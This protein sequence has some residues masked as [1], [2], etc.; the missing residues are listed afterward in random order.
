MPVLKYNSVFD[1]IQAMV[2]LKAKIDAL[3]PAQDTCTV[4][5]DRTKKKVENVPF[6]YHCFCTEGELKQNGAIK[7]G[8]L[9]FNV[10]DAVLVQAKSPLFS[11]WDPISARYDDCKVVGRATG[12]IGCSYRFKVTRSYDNKVLTD[13]KEDH[14]SFSAHYKNKSG[15]IRDLYIS[16]VTYDKKTQFHTLIITASTGSSYGTFGEM[17]DLGG[18]WVRVNGADA[19]TTQYPDVYFQDAAWASQDKILP[20]AYEITL[21]YVRLTWTFTP[22]VAQTGLANDLWAKFHANVVSWNGRK[23]WPVWWP[24]INDWIDNFFVEDPWPAP[25]PIVDFFFRSEARARMDYTCICEV[26]HQI[27]E[28]FF[29]PGASGYMALARGNSAQTKCASFNGVETCWDFNWWEYSELWIPCGGTLISSGGMN[30]SWAPGSYQAE[31]S[32]LSGSDSGYI[33]L[34]ITPNQAG[35]VM[36]RGVASFRAE[37][38]APTGRLFL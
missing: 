13:A 17:V 35:W 23:E 30:E 1:Q 10:G 25:E 14:V 36:I 21:P 37:L 8:S 5:L 34:D 4:T 29:G 15:T 6:F 27:R 33:Q 22:G 11:E 9:A 32:K 12:L 31:I 16:S 28:T 26:P 3:D 24:Y 18:C 38:V 19:M 20:G 7:F 2:E